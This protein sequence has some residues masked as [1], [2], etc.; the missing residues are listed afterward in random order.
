MIRRFLLVDRRVLDAIRVNLGSIK[1]AETSK[2]KESWEYLMK[3]DSDLQIGPAV[4]EPVS[5]VA[6][7]SLKSAFVELHSVNIR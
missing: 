7:S 2:T 5:T 1:T 3:R 4:P 6:P